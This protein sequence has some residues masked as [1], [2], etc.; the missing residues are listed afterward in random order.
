M[1]TLKRKRA[2]PEQLVYTF[3]IVTNANYFLLSICYKLTDITFVRQS[4]IKVACE[5]HNI[6]V[7]SITSWSRYGIY[8]RTIKR[9]DEIIFVK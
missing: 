7:N 2:L 8:A 4:S 9:A 5:L 3:K 1:S 6:L